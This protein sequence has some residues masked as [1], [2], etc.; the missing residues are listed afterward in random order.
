M[1]CYGNPRPTTPFI[2]RFAE[3]AVLFE[4]AFAYT[5]WTLPSHLSIFT[6]RY[7]GQFFKGMNR[8]PEGYLLPASFVLPSATPTLASVLR[9]AGYDTWGIHCGGFMNPVFGF[10][11]GFNSYE[12]AQSRQSVADEAAKRIRDHADN[13]QPFFMFFHTYIPHLP[14]EYE[15]FFAKPRGQRPDD[16]RNLDLSKRLLNDKPLLP[17]DPEADNYAWRP[18]PEGIEHVK[19]VYNR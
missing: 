5:S 18:S 3:E 17:L 13:D 4:K 16:V 7:A 10:G 11:N 1:H 6:G 19:A 12:K 9:D 2:D 14:Y 15:K 8:H